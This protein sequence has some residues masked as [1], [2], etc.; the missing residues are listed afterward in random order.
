M[1]WGELS[2]KLQVILLAAQLC[3]YITLASNSLHIYWN[4]TLRSIS[5][6]TLCQR[7]TTLCLF[8]LTFCVFYTIVRSGP[9]S[10]SSRASTRKHRVATLLMSTWWITWVQCFSTNWRPFSTYCSKSS[11]RYVRTGTGNW[12]KRWFF[13]TFVIF[14]HK[15]S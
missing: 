3:P 2:C 12:S 4:L 8:F 7:I 9:P 1:V 6:G 11:S 15:I 14:F 5:D 10:P 13:K